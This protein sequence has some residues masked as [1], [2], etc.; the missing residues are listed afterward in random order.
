MLDA[1]F[2]TELPL[3][4][5][6]VVA[7]AVVLVLLL[8]VMWIFKRLAGDRLGTS[9][10]RGR[11]PRLAVIDAAAID[12]RR[13]LV[14]VRRDNVEHLVMIGGPSD[15]L[16][17]QNIVRAVPVAPAREAPAPRAAG[18][19]PARPAPEPTRPPAEP[20][21]RAPRPEPAPRT[22][23]EPPPRR[24]SEFERP[25][26]DPAALAPRAPEPRALRMPPPRFDS[27]PAPV[28]VHPAP[29][30][31]DTNLASMAQKLETALR[32]PASNAQDLTATRDIGSEFSPPPLSEP[33]PPTAPESNG[34]APHGPAAEPPAQSAA[35]SPEKT[36]A[37]P[38]SPATQSML[39][40]LEAEMAN[41][42]G[43]TPDTPEKK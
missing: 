31:A 38:G 11:Q 10:P 9:A 27:E 34:Q 8:A 33:T 26:L 37:S 4:V 43:R 22:R 35:V 29:P 2:N 36:P 3:V 30:T 14:L 28:E 6:L 19:M 32:R 13:R 15:V 23:A 25:R 39:D 20:A 42:L 1:L 17:E 40:S 21:A 24:S 18:D 12:G 41:L 5:K 7:F 16:I